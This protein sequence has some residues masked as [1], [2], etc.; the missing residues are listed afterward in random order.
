MEKMFILAQESHEYKCSGRCKAIVRRI[1]EQVRAETD[2]WSQMQEM[3]AQVRGEMEDLHASRDFWENRAYNSDCEVQSL[4]HAVEEWKEKALRYENKTNELQL[5]LSVAKDEIE[6]SKLDLVP[7]VEQI[8]KE[9][10]L[11]LEFKLKKDRQTGE[12]EK[13]QRTPKKDLLPP[14]SLGKQLAKEKNIF[15]RRLKE[16]GRDIGEIGRKKKVSSACDGGEI[17]GSSRSPLIDV[18]S[19]NMSPLTRQLSRSGFA[20]FRSPESLRLRESFKKVINFH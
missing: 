3:V 20:F 7:L 6:K 18:H 9:K 10:K 12:E 11:V 15:I 1:L 19:N 4:R 17:V 8:E 16:H 2:Q 13:N 14:L 5:E